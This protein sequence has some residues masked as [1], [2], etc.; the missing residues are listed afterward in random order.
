MLSHSSEDRSLKPVRCV[1]QTRPGKRGS[2]RLVE[3]SLFA[4]RAPEAAGQC[5]L[6]LSHSVS[7][8]GHNAFCSAC[9]GTS[10][11]SPS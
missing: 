5:W 6:W 8:S 9:A 4:S 11:A 2:L 1:S 10:W 7:A 3:S